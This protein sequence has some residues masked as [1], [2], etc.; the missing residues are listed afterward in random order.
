MNQHGDEANQQKTSSAERSQQT[1]LDNVVNSTT[2]ATS[3][4]VMI[5]LVVGIAVD[6]LNFGKIEPNDPFGIA[7]EFTCGWNAVHDDTYDDGRIYYIDACDADSDDMSCDVQF[8]G[9]VWLA[10]GILGICAQALVLLLMCLT[11][12]PIHGKERLLRLAALVVACA[13]VLI[14]WTV[15]YAKGC[16]NYNDDLDLVVLDGSDIGIEKLTFK[17]GP[18]M[19]LVVTAWSLGVVAT[20]LQLSNVI[21]ANTLSVQ[22]RSSGPTK[23][24]AGQ[25]T[26]LEKGDG[27]SIRS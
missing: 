27:A 17:L 26:D 21:R 12:H 1:V 22:Q 2:V 18:S 6:E 24:T 9:E 7:Q 10:F 25:S 14:Q 16:G 13:F 19:I 11:V 15:W 8:I 3:V 5:L 4:V 23:T 20:L